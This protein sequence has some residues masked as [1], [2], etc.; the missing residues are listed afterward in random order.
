LKDSNGFLIASNRKTGF[1]GFVIDLTNLIDLYRN[2]KSEYNF[3]YILSFKLSQDHLETFFSAVR[4]RGGCNNNPSCLHFKGAYKKLIVKHEISGSKYGN[5]SILDAANILHV[6]SSIKSKTTDLILEEDVGDFELDVENE[7]IFFPNSLLSNFVNDIV[8]YIA[9]FVTRKAKSKILCHICNSQLQSIDC[10]SKLIKFKNRGG[11]A[12]PSKYV[13]ELCREL[14]RTI[15]CTE[16]AKL[17]NKKNIKELI[18]LQ[19]IRKMPNLFSDEMMTNHIKN[20]PILDNHRMRI[21]LIKIISKI[22]LTL[23]I[24]YECKKTAEA[25]NKNKIRNKLNKVILFKNE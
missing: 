24:H 16:K 6:S 12:I 13:I 19:T 8:V 21:Q 22:Y 2:L 5:C 15:R 3:E 20:Q 7:N 14:E 1:L 18:T 4:S 25:R 23:R 10:N 9:G 11:L 17:L